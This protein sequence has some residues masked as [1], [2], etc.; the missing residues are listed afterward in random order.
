MF[1]RPGPE[2]GLYCCDVLLRCGLAGKQALDVHAD[3]AVQELLDLPVGA[4]SGP[5]AAYHLD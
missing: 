5:A 2:G 3:E 4:E 1:H